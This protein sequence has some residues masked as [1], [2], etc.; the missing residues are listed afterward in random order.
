MVSH[1]ITFAS[2]GYEVYARRLT[3]SARLCGFDTAQ[4]F[5]PGDLAGTNFALRN[6][7]VLSARRGGGYWLW[8]PYVIREFLNEL[9]AGEV[10]LYSDAGR[11]SYYQFSHFPTHLLAHATLSEQGF[12]AGVAIPHLGPIGQ[13]TKMDCLQVME[14]DFPSFYEKPIVQTTWSVWTK[15]D[16]AMAF[17]DIWLEYCEDPRCLTDA[18]NVLGRKNLP[19]FVDHRHDQSV[20]SILAHKLSAPFLDCSRTTVQRA[21]ELRPQSEV[22]HLF[23]KRAENLNDLLG[24]ATPIILVREYLRLRGLR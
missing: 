10:L 4:C 9:R 15:T 7:E 22:A 21:I 20:C 8:K 2:R 6:S 1:F 17:L 3:D 13:W 19:N 16:S 12:L 18:P 5:G 24:G 23:Y 11:S 14:A